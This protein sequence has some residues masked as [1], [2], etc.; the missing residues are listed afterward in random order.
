MR[1]EKEIRTKVEELEAKIST[2]EEQGDKERWNL[3]MLDE[4]KDGRHAL[5]WVLGEKERL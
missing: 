5:R 4:M 2:I 3:S 1:T